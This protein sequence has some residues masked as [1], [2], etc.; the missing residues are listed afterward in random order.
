MDYLSDI[1]CDL[2][3]L[4]TAARLH[5]FGELPKDNEGSIFTIND[6]I[7]NCIERLGGENEKV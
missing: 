4:K 6:L 5:G 1:L 2:H 3:D 7:D